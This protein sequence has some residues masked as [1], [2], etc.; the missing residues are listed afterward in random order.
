MSIAPTIIVLT[1]LGKKTGDFFVS[2]LRTSLTFQ[3]SRTN[4]LTR[5]VNAK[6]IIPVLKDSKLISQIVIQSLL[7]P[8]I[9]NIDLVLIPCNSV[10]IANPYLKQ[11][12]GDC[13]IP[14]DNATLSLIKHDKRHGRFL[15]LGTS[16]T[17]ESCMYQ[18]ALQRLGC[19]SVVLTPDIQASLDDFIFEELVMGEMNTSHLHTLREL[20]S[21]YM[22]LL[23]AD[24]VILACT[25]LCYLVQV[26]STP[27]PFEVDSLQALHDAGI[28]RLHTLLGDRQNHAN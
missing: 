3:F 8:N 5:T 14:I 13:F 15:I 21:S 23:G 25:E 6:D 26:F 4:L 12:F 22:K 19:E 16:T 20:E 11:T 28:E 17:V 24:H 2:R 7:S 1:G 27:L 18:D 9:E 10:H